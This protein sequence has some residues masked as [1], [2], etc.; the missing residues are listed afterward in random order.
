MILLISRCEVS[1][2][3]NRGVRE[4]ACYR[5]VLLGGTGHPFLGLQ[6]SDSTRLVID[7]Q[8]GLSSIATTSSVVHTPLAMKRKFT[9]A[10]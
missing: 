8:R 10:E 3:L 4:G 7:I 6:W 9:S 2:I 1:D 5:L